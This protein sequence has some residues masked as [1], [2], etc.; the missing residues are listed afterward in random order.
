M[1]NPLKYLFTLGL[2]IAALGF[3]VLWMVGPKGAGPAGL[4]YDTVPAAK[5]QIRKIV[6]TSGP[7]RAL[8]TVSI[9]SQL[10]GQIDALNVDYN[11]EVKAGDVLATIDARTFDA[12]VAQAKADLVAARAGLTNQ[13]AALNKTLSVKTLAELTMK[14]QDSLQQ[15]GYASTATLDTARRDVEVAAADIAVSKAQIESA[16]AVIAQREA[17]LKQADVDLERT[18]II[19]PINGTVIARTI[20]LGQTVA[21]SF[22]APEL[23]KIAQDLRRIRIEAQVNEADVGSVAVGNAVAFTVDAYPDRSFEGNVT[24][25]RLS[26]T[27][28]QNIVTYTVIIE[29]SNEDRKLFPGMTANVQIEVSKK[30]D[31]LRVPNDALRFRPRGEAADQQGNGNGNRGE[32]QIARLKTDLQLTEPQEKAIRDVLAKLFAARSAAPGGIDTSIADPAALRQRVQ[33]AIEQTLPPLLSDEQRPAFDKWKRGRENTKSGAVN[34]L[35]AGGTPERR[36]V[37]LGISDDQFSE[38]ISGQLTEGERVVVR[39]RDA[40]K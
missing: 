5:G 13:E 19:A 4:V 24:Q 8:V 17:A 22:Q 1:A 14:R 23:F 26:A 25:V 32:R 11:S 28:L 29:A 12:R 30:D 27:E 34:V 7:V 15:K 36:F 33:A 35:D 9:G 37:R 18:K 6:A 31:V 16:K 40:Q 39:A 10:S 21:A 3:G 20:D 2:P 38:I